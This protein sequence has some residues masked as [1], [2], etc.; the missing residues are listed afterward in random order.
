MYSTSSIASLLPYASLMS[1][2]SA[3]QYARSKGSV[4]RH[5]KPAGRP[6]DPPND[7]VVKSLLQMHNEAP[8]TSVHV[9]AVEGGEIVCQTPYGNETLP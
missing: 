6:G 1:I 8:Q 2:H 7:I 5:L 3:F 4:A 9:D